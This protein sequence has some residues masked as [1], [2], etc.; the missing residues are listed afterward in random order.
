VVKWRSWF[1]RKV[2]TFD[3]GIS[4]CWKALCLKHLLSVSLLFHRYELWAFLNFVG[5]LILFLQILFILIKGSLRLLHFYELF[6]YLRSKFEML[7]VDFN[8]KID[9]MVFF[10]WFIIRNA[11][12]ITMILTKS[13]WTRWFYRNFEV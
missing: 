10:L 13:R 2:N 1:C 11:F 6:S 12:G 7:V 3:D 5:F 8:W 9:G 4:K